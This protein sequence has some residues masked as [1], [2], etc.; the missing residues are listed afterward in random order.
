[1]KKPK[2]ER[3]EK[4]GKVAEGREVELTIRVRAASS[5]QRPIEVEIR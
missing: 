3:H 4:R 1:M 2:A 5:R